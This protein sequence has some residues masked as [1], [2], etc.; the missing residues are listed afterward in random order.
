[1]RNALAIARKELS[2]YFTT[3]LAYFVIMGM[4]VFSAFSFISSLGKFIQVQEIARAYTWAR[5]PPEYN[6][7]RNL[8]DGVILPLWGWV[9]IFAVLAAPLLSMGL[10][11]RE[12]RERTFEL[13]MTAPLRPWEL[14]TGKYLGALGVTAVTFGSVG[15]FPLILSVFGA[16]ESGKA[17]EWQT[18]GLGFFGLMLLGALGVAVTMLISSFTQTELLAAFIG[19]VVMLLW[20]LIGFAAEAAG[21]PWR[22]IIQDVG[23]IGHLEAMMAGVLELKGLVMFLSGIGFCLLLTVLKIESERWA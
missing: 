19:L 7:Y 9:L 18:V 14:V 5:M 6:A 11:A 4:V 2:I 12:K 23:L 10:F 16:S 20:L 3:P 17:L 13:L 1:M 22:S 8:T 15:V 21:P